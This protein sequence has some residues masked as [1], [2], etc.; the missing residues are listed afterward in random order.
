[1]RNWCGARPL[2]ERAGFL[3]RDARLLCQFGNHPL[4][5][6][7]IIDDRSFIIGIQIEQPSDCAESLESVV[8]SYGEAEFGARSKK[9][10]GLID[11]TRHQVIDQNSDVRSL[12]SEDQRIFSECGSSGVDS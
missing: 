3:R 9:A 4:I 12:A 5:A 1:M 8:L 10:I 11:S 2:K 7:T 6:K